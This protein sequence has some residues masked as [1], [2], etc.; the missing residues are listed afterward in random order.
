MTLETRRW[1]PD[2]HVKHLFN[3]IERKDFP[4][5]SLYIQAMPGR[6]QRRSGR[7]L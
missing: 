3:A 5:W 6:S 1:Y 2:C 7:H 4:G